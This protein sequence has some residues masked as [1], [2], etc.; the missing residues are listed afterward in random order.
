MVCVIFGHPAKV[1]S[2]I[3]TFMYSFHM[4]LFLMISGF[5][6]RYEKY[7]TFAQ[8]V[9]NQAKRLLVPYVV[10]Y[11]VCTPLWYI[12]HRVFGS[13]TVSLLEEAAGLFVA[14]AGVT[15]MVNGALWFLPALFLTTVVFWLMCDI[16]A[17]H[18]VDPAGLAAACFLLGACL[19]QF[20]RGPYPWSINCIPMMV[21][22]F[23]LGW[24]YGQMRGKECESRIRSPQ[25]AGML[26]IAI[27]AIGIW[28]AFENG[29]ISVHGN[30]YRTIALALTSSVGLSLAFA[31]MFERLPRIRPLEFMGRQSLIFFGLHI[32]V[33]RFLEYFPITRPTM[34]AHPLW[35]AALTLLI[36]FP[37]VGIIVKIRQLLR[38][39][40]H[41]RGELS[42]A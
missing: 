30:R 19:A 26:C 13:S 31:M 1:P 29:K 27:M 8:C 32:P 33:M 40:R 12:N 20:T 38:L 16:S 28:A 3:E 9:T 4:P 42:N 15:P 36:L 7:A 2:D 10:L 18:K 6:F 23:Y 17:K 25:L 21:T 39:R 22:F 11:L 24:A 34:L 14:N 35:C 37:L 41:G 5:T